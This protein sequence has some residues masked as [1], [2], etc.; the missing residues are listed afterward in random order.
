MHSGSNKAS[1]YD[2][3]EHEEISSDEYQQWKLIK[4]NMLKIIRQSHENGVTMF[5]WK[6]A[7][8]DTEK[9]HLYDKVQNR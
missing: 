4:L 2:S 1:N 7:Y 8:D 5:E 6:K 9:F 3:H